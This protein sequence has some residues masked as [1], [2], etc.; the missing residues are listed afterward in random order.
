MLLLLDA[1]L[2]TMYNDTVSTWLYWGML[3]LLSWLWCNPYS[4]SSISPAVLGGT[5]DHTYFSP[6]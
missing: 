6:N 1:T 3:V 4:L 2:Y 5:L